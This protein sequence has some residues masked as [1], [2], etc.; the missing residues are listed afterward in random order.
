MHEPQRPAGLED[1]RSRQQIGRLGCLLLFEG[2]EPRC[3]EK[4]ALLEYR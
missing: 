3:L 1:S 4:V 2:R